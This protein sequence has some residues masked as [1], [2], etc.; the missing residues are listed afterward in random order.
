MK[1]YVSTLLLAAF[2]LSA[3]ADDFD[4]SKP[5]GFCTVSSRTD[6]SSTYNCTGGGCYT[7]PIPSDFTGKVIELKS[8]GPSADMK[9]KIQ[10]AIKQND[11][12]I[13]DG[14]NGDF[15]ISSSIGFERGNKTILGI[16]NA[17]LCTKFQVTAEMKKALN[18]AGVPNMNTSGGGGKLPNGQNGS[19]EAEFNTRKIIIEMTSDNNE[20]YRKSGIFSLNK[21]NVIIRN[22]TFVGPGS[23]DV[24]GYDLISATGAKHCWV[25]HCAFSDGMDGN[26]DITN[27]SDFNTVSYCT[28][29][30]TERSYMHQNTNLVGSSDDE[31]A[32]TLNTT[33][34][35]NWWGT[36]CN[37]RMPMA[38]VGKIHM[39]NNY[40]SCANNSSSVNPRTNSEFLI[41]G[42]YFDTGVK[43]YYS[44]N[45]AT[46]VTWTQNNYI[47]EANSRPASKGSTV[48]VPYTYSVLPYA[49]VPA[50]VK[51]QAG[52]T[53]EYSK[54]DD[55]TQEGPT[56]EVAYNVSFNT[57]E[58][59][60]TNGY[61]SFGDSGNKHNLNSK[62]TGKYNGT[63]Y[64]Q[65]LKMEGSTLIQ[66]TNSATATIIIV[67]SDWESNDVAHGTPKTLKFDGT[68]LDM[69]SATKPADSEGV[70]VYTITGVSAGTHNITRGSGESGVF[71]V[72]V[73]EAV[74]SGIQS[75][76]AASSI[77]ATEYY[78]LNGRRLAEP[79][80]GIN[81]RVERMANGQ[82]VTTKVIK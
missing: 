70:L 5:F 13:L 12:V 44:E 10:N 24:G 68:E 4:T 53:L 28:F 54:S 78:D 6:A 56:E 3:I 26:F 48:T 35:F 50:I 17:R 9:A 47:A 55:E 15:I 42:N 14:S 74:P 16:N 30:Y 66:F 60:S 37:Q 75:T 38:R 39:L 64:A 65:G 43:K 45:G 62:F 19:E 34:A 2:S 69:S 61:F 67:Q 81:I 59:Q 20:N 1:K 29:S 40:F 49:D 57:E 52:A 71:Y 73:R 82:A 46:A 25:D 27:A 22:I 32:G 72:E 36:G 23:I 33:F 58:K 41:D 11:V 21:E 79:Q 76:T 63:D 18:D 8:D 31:T 51:A 77:V 80:R 7:Y